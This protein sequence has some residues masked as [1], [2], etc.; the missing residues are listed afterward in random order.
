MFLGRLHHRRVQR[1]DTNTSVDIPVII[2]RSEE[3]ERTTGARD[4]H[5]SR[6]RQVKP[7]AAVRSLRLPSII[8]LL[9]FDNWI[10]C[11]ST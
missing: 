2:T 3:C 4:V 1:D 7:A 9:V 10:D 6:S 8:I 5:S 11:S